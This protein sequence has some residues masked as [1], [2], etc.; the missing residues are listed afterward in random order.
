MH[1]GAA[2]LHSDRFGGG[3]TR[4]KAGAS[5]LSPTNQPRLIG[6]LIRH[7]D[8]PA[9]YPSIRP[10]VVAINFNAT[11]ANQPPCCGGIDYFQG[12]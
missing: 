5:I 8:V 11:A 9:T 4:R 7:I 1:N 3:D 2:S 6:D 12:L 10:P